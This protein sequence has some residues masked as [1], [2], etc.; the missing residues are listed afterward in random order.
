MILILKSLAIGIGLV[1]TVAL[2]LNQLVLFSRLKKLEKDNDALMLWVE[3]LIK[4]SMDTGT[5]KEDIPNAE[6]KVV[7]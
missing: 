2:M 6:F 3:V 5:E 7:H 1:V 4:L